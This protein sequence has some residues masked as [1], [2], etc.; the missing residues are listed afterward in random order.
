MTQKIIFSP[1]PH[2]HTGRTTGGIMR[3]VLIALAPAVAC[4][5]WFF[6]LPAL[7]VLVTSV[8]SCV[9][10]EWLITRYMLRRPVSLS[11]CSAI[12]TGVLLALTLPSG[13]P[14][15]MAAAGG[16]VAIGI[17]KM[18][19]GGLGCNIF[20]PALVGRVFLLI[21]FPVAITTW[22]LPASPFTDT[23]GA[24]GATVLSQ[25]KMGLADSGALDMLGM[26][27][28][29]MGGSMGEVSAAALLLGFI[30]LLALRIIKWHI[31]VSIVAGLVLVDL[32]AGFPP[33]TDILSGGLLIG[34]IFMA[35]D[36]V[37]SP[38][39]RRGMLLYGLMIGIITAVIRRWGS[40]PEGI[41]FAILIMNGATP[42]INR[43]MHNARFSPRRKEAA[44]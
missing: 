36:Y 23:D 13:L 35:T 39:S 12:L 27:T 44:A 6:G 16:I 18:A 33:L 40:Y 42:L 14:L 8:A 1:S 19:F 11:D 43:Y 34:A 37:T 22:P 29:D 15:W 9:A 17:A 32:I 24:T 38:M 41:S 25:L 28:G 5:L 21:S 31:P 30:Y 4:A 7:W 10:T 26:F 3:H 2:I 20:N